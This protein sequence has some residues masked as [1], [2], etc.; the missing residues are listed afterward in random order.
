MMN[1]RRK[2]C[3]QDT[4]QIIHNCA[5]V[6]GQCLLSVFDGHGMYGHEVS[7]FLRKM[8]PGIV[9]NAL[10]RAAKNTGTAI[11]EDRIMKTGLYEGFLMTADEIFKQHTI[12]ITYSGSTAVSVLLKGQLLVCANVGDSRAVIGRKT[13]EGW[14]VIPLSHDHKP[15]L[16]YEK[17]RIEACGGRV[18]PHRSKGST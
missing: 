4:Y 18:E 13:P 15:D 8:L 5:G 17:K 1:G 6:R 9:G 2:K 16:P 11:D 14:Q 10:Q 12:N 7:G 3:N